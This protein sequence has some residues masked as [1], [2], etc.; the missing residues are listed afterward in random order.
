MQTD[1]S[2]STQAEA[3]DLQSCRQNP[4]KELLEEGATDDEIETLICE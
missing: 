2:Y 4:D 1:R 3:M